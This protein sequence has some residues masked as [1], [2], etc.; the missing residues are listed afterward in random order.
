MEECPDCIHKDEIIG[1]LDDEIEELK[2]RIRYLEN[3]EHDLKQELESLKNSM[4]SIYTE[5]QPYV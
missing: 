5:A 2:G 1:K 4:Y 3:E